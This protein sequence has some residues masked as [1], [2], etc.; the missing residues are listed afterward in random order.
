MLLVRSIR[1]TL[2]LALHGYCYPKSEIVY[3]QDITLAS[4]YTGALSTAQS[5]NR[6]STFVLNCVRLVL[7]SQWA[8]SDLCTLHFHRS[9]FQMAQFTLQCYINIESTYIEQQRSKALYK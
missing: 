4:F 3:I 1:K 2:G 7:P 5:V 6:E 9:V 8:S